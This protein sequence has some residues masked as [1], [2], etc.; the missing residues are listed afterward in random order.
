MPKTMIIFALT[1]WKDKYTTDG[2]IAFNWE[3]RTCK[4]F[5]IDT[6]KYITIPVEDIDYIAS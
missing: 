3:S 6:K 2:T 1:P 5:D 4:F